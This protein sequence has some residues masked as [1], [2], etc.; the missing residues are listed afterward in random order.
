MTCVVAV[1]DGNTIYAGADTAA[2]QNDEIYQIPEP[3]IF[4][5]NSM[6]FGFC[7]SYRLGQ[8]VR[9]RS[10]LPSPGS[11]YTDLI[12]FLAREFVPALKAA[13]EA[14]G[15][16]LPGKSFLGEGTG[17]LVGYNGELG[18]VGS[19]LAVMS[20]SRPYLSIGSGRTRA[21]PALY[22][23][24]QVGTPPGR[25]LVELTLE[26]AADY[27]LTVR[28]PYQFVEL[29]PSTPSTVRNSL[30]PPAVSTTDRAARGV[31]PA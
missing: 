3:K 12:T 8:I 22:A 23:L 18:M 4:L 6:L 28:G 1:T 21:Y 30:P 31:M 9:Y 13:V 14:D 2:G 10:N 29:P 15:A 25:R 5:H 11:D 19:T 20:A 27:T 17:L 24:T 16:A 26:A 7:G